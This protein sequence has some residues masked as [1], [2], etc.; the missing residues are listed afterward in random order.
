MADSSIRV[1]G[2]KL[3]AARDA[4][5]WGQKKLAAE[6]GYKL[7]VIEK[8]EQG[9]YFSLPCLEVVAG[10]LGVPLDS[11]LITS[12]KV[13]QGDFYE[14]L[15][16]HWWEFIQPVDLA[17]VSFVQIVPIRSMRSVQLKGTAYTPELAV[18]GMWKSL[19]ACVNPESCELFYYWQGEQHSHV[20][21]L[22]T[23]FG[24]VSFL[25]RGG[26]VNCGRGFFSRC[27]VSDF[28]AN[29]KQLVLFERAGGEEVATMVAEHQGAAKELLRQK[30]ERGS[31]MLE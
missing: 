7:S 15:A 18:R 9:T 11:L 19:A 13:G 24:V 2:A 27:K 17:V 4:K 20:T 21:D 14:H 3:K 31:S 10:K 22:F 16:G 5:D 8:L 26:V 6:A 28:S 1:D 23:G 29:T 25:A 30:V 12:E